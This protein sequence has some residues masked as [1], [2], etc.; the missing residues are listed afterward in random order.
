MDVLSPSL[1]R[2]LLGTSEVK[3]ENNGRDDGTCSRRG[4]KKN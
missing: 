2:D 3:W 1:S 4:T